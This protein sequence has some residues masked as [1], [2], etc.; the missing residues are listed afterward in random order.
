LQIFKVS[1]FNCSPVMT[2]A[3]LL[4]ALCFAFSKQAFSEISRDRT[5][6]PFSTIISA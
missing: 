1:D 5:Y 2:V 3:A 6:S 4:R